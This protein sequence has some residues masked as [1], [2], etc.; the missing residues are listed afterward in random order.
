[1][2]HHLTQ[3]IMST[4]KINSKTVVFITGAFVGNNGWDS[5][6]SYFEGK[7]Y[8][9]SAPAWPHKNASPS[10]LRERQGN[11]SDLATLHLSEVLDHYAAIIQKLPEKPILIGH[12][13]GGLMSQILLDRGLASAAVSIH[14]VPPQGVLPT[15]FSFYKAT[16]KPLGFFTSA[17]KTHLMSL[18]EWQYAF[19]NGMSLA[20]Q[21]LSYEQNAIPESK[22][23]LRDGLTKVA[24]IDFS[25]PHAPLLLTSGD[26]DQIIPA[27]STRATYKKYKN[28]NGV[29][30]TD[31]KDFAGRNHYVLGQPT[32]KEDADYILDWIAGH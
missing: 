21:K 30:V 6:K 26:L 31:Y 22:T 24:K 25:K 32:W 11:D 4:S 15:Q 20:D 14:P 2:S 19:T 13:L 10:A 23:V 5:W 17:K 12:S 7:G 29:S 27:G 28:G 16:W 18:K 9:T 1:M 3:K 8:S